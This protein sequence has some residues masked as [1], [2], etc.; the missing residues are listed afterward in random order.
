MPKTVEF[1]VRDSWSNMAS[2]LDEGL[3]GNSA[4]YSHGRNLICGADGAASAC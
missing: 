1:I 3:S 2:H 4:R